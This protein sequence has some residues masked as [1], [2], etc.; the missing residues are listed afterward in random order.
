M[1]NPNLT[2]ARLRELINYEPEAGIF[3]WRKI[4]AA[5]SQRGPGTIL[6]CGYLQISIDGVKYQGHRLAWLHFYGQWPMNVVDHINGDKLDNRIANLRDVTTAVNLQN[7]HGASSRNACG[8]T[9]VSF[10]KRE[11]AWSASLMVDGKV[12]RLGFH[13]T[14]ELAHDAYITAK[15]QYH[16]GWVW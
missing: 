12:K 15:L 8:Y 3:K 7:I 13:K 11:N 2:A 4:A 1:S 9:G 6:N 10:H 14:P 16:P 5:R